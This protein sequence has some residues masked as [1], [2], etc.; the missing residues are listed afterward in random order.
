MCIRDSFFAA[1]DAPALPLFDE[2]EE[3]ASLDDLDPWD[4]WS[5]DDDDDDL[6]EYA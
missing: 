2:S 1:G 3:E 6:G 5:D 4:D